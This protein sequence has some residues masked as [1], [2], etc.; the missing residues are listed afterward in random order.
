MVNGCDRNAIRSSVEFKSRMGSNIHPMTRIRDGSRKCALRVISGLR[1]EHI[2][3][4]RI[5][6]MVDGGD[7][8]RKNVV[9]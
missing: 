7:G 9:S 1:R 4:D 5:D 6:V 2:L 3:Y 8:R